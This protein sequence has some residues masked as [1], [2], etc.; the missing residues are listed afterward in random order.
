MGL[1]DYLIHMNN[2]FTSLT[3][4]LSQFINK[5]FKKLNMLIISQ[6]L[7][8]FRLLPQEQCGESKNAGNFELS[9]IFRYCL[10]FYFSLK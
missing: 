9:F 10:A 8:D 2:I 7:R 1:N 5:A 6:E 3:T 4:E